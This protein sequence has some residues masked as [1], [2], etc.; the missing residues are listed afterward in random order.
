[1]AVF[2]FDGRFLMEVDLAP[3]QGHGSGVDAVITET[4]ARPGRR[5]GRAHNEMRSLTLTHNPLRSA[6]GSARLQLGATD[7]LVAVYGP[8]DGP[9]I[10][11]DPENLHV[12]VSYRRRDASNTTEA[13]AADDATVARNI[14][15][16]IQ[17]TLLMQLFPRKAIIV[18]VQILSDR[19]SVVTAVFNAA[20]VALLESGVP[21][22]AVPVAACVSI[23]SGALTVDPLHVEEREANAVITCVFDTRIDDDKGFL[24]V[25]MEGDCHNQQLFLAAQSTC[26]QLAVKT[27]SFLSSSLEHQSRRRFVWNAS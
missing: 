20:V 23:T 27:R 8:L 1:M 22:C 2:L 3:F 13:S 15:Q 9:V 14:R 25:C 18:A 17:D 7:V 24:S 4:S 21:M 19:G 6:D 26:R 11:Q 10:K 12:H 5:D 16:L